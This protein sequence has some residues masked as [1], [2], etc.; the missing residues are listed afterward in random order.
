MR[1]GLHVIFLSACWLHLCFV[2]KQDC[3]FSSVLH[4]CEDIVDCLFRLHPLP[5]Q[6]V[7]SAGTGGTSR[8]GFCSLEWIEVLSFF[9]KVSV[10]SHLIS[11][12]EW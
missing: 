8:D 12:V 9:V 1:L 10:I 2:C 7:L 11:D 3:V 4:N 6:L 5:V